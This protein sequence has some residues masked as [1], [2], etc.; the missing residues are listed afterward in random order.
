MNDEKIQGNTEIF[1][2]IQLSIAVISFYFFKKRKDYSVR[3]EFKKKQTTLLVN[4]AQYTNVP[5]KIN[6]CHASKGLLA[7]IIMIKLIC[8]CFN[9]TDTCIAILAY[10]HFYICLFCLKTIQKI[11]FHNDIAIRQSVWL[12]TKIDKIF[13][14][15]FCGR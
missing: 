3:H 2:V 8:L 6:Q 1:A 9:T 15:N 4:K 14:K 13:F 11:V 5:E 12:K 10:K 7:Q